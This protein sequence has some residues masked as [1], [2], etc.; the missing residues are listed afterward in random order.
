M[1]GETSNEHEP[2]SGLKEGWLP[3][4]MVG[5]PVWGNQLYEFRIDWDYEVAAVDAARR[6]SDGLLALVP[7]WKDADHLQ[8]CVDAGDAIGVG[9]QILGFSEVNHSVRVRALMRMRLTGVELPPGLPSVD[10]ETIKEDLSDPRLT[11]RADEVRDEAVK[12]LRDRGSDLPDDIWIANPEQLADLLAPVVFDSG[13]VEARRAFQATAHARLALVRSQ[14]ETLQLMN[15][16]RTGVDEKPFPRPRPQEPASQAPQNPA[17]SLITRLADRKVST[18]LLRSLELRLRSCASDS[19]NGRRDLA[20]IESVPLGV[21]RHPQRSAAEVR[22]ALLAELGEFDAVGQWLLDRLPILRR[23]GRRGSPGVGR[24]LMLVGD[25]GVGKSRRAE[26][27]ARAAG[28]PSFTIPAGGLS[29]AISLRGVRSAFSRAQP[30]MIVSALIETG[31]MNPVIIIDEVDKLGRSLYNGD[32]ADAL[33]HLLE[34][35]QA[36]AFRDD[37]L[38]VALPLEAVTIICTGNDLDLV[39]RAL[40]DRLDVVRVAPYS[41]QQKRHIVRAVVIPELRGEFRA[42]E[43]ALAIT[44]QAIDELINRHAL[45]PGVRGLISDV[46]TLFLKFKSRRGPVRIGVAEVGALLGRPVGV[47]ADRCVICGS[48]ILDARELQRLIAQD[49]PV[50]EAPVSVPVAV[51]TSCLDRPTAYFMANADRIR[52]RVAADVVVWRWMVAA[53]ERRTDEGHGEAAPRR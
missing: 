31:C 9:A 50:A 39:P 24:G 22:R 46:R 28:L 25:P 15:A 30:G 36:K 12:Y 11:A 1:A 52:A 21:Y 18:E 17:S 3:A 37:F 7:V 6:D 19:E 44:D 35:E 43:K 20:I 8:L 2:Q 33:L 49:L 26:A 47:D 29:D 53:P 10:G 16:A 27:L 13:S 51:H 23:A 4:L 14:L 45:E 48:E 34:P 5:V 41:R 40:R 32:P 38:E 42:S